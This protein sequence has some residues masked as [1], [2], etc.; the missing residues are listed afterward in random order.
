MSQSWLHQFYVNL[1]LPSSFYHLF[2]LSFNLTY[3]N[4]GKGIFIYQSKSGINW[5]YYNKYMFKHIYILSPIF[6]DVFIPHFGHTISP[7]HNCDVCSLL[8]SP[9]MTSWDITWVKGGSRKSKGSN[10]VNIEIPEL[11]TIWV[12]HRLKIL[13]NLWIIM[14]KSDKSIINHR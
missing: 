1:K 5:R 7:G 2:F 6:N 14:D 11:T 3:I 9:P 12:Y 13:L 10:G 8:C 4:F